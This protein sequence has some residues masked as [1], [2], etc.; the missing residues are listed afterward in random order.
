MKGYQSAS[1]FLFL[2]ALWFV[3]AEEI[4]YAAFKEHQVVPDGKDG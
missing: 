3:M 4:D 1:I 2:F